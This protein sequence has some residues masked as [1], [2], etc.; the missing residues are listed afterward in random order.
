[1]YKL[2]ILSTLFFWL[3]NTNAQNET[4]KASFINKEQPV[5]AKNLDTEI[6]TEQF[7]KHNQTVKKSSKLLSIKDINKKLMEHVEKSNN[8]GRSNITVNP[9]N[10]KSRAVLLNINS[11]PE[12]KKKD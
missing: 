12:E 7:E 4:K 8:K 2:F 6:P 1:M 10:N 5:S 3:N 11:K 9:N